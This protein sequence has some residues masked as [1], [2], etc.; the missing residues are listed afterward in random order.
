M[1]SLAAP[2]PKAAIINNY[3]KKALMQ[4]IDQLEKTLDIQ[5]VTL[6]S[7]FFLYCVYILLFLSF[8]FIFFIF[9]YSLCHC[10]CFCIVFDLYLLHILYLYFYSI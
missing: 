10:I 4:T 2:I 6:A 8:D 1:G 9:S 7:R 3:R 5:Q